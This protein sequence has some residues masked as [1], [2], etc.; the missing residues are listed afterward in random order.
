MDAEPHVGQRVNLT[1]W[2]P[3]LDEDNPAIPSKGAQ[4]SAAQKNR[5]PQ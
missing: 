5:S 4:P 2:Y 3:L 1:L